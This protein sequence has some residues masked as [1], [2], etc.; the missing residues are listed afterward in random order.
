[1]MKKALTIILA[2]SMLLSFGMFAFA[3]DG[4]PNEGGNWVAGDQ[5]SGFNLPFL[6]E[7]SFDF[8]SIF[9]AFGNMAGLLDGF[10]L[11][12]ILDLFG[13]I[14]DGMGGMDLGDLFSMDMLSGELMTGFIDTVGDL[15][16]VDMS[17]MTDNAV[18]SF[19][20]NLYTGIYTGGPGGGEPDPEPEPDDPE[21]PPANDPP[22][23]DPP[24]DTGVEMTAAFVAAGVLLTAI[25]AAFVL[26]KKKVVG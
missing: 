14:G 19:F 20:A 10:S 26:R 25:C 17:I 18:F 15:L 8:D 6:G 1:M 5:S 24:P 11:D 13:G 23:Y 21:P 7:G 16:G 22:P 12:G 2:L 3:E 4:E 9:G